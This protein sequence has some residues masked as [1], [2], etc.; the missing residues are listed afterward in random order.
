[1]FRLVSTVKLLCILAILNF[2]WMSPEVAARKQLRLVDFL[3]CLSWVSHSQFRS[4]YM[5][6]L[7]K[8]LGCSPDTTSFT[9]LCVVLLRSIQFFLFALPR[10]RPICCIGSNITSLCGV[11]C[12]VTCLAGWTNSFWLSVCS[13]TVLIVIAAITIF[14]NKVVGASAF[15]SRNLL[16]VFSWLSLFF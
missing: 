16:S 3:F 5:T 7:V 8:M 13:N 15:V 14:G 9:V 4:D 1:M 12:F 11:V 10:K 2:P 6:F